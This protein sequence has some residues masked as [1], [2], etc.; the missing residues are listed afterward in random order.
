VQ[1]V[2]P[3]SGRTYYWNEQTHASQW[4][5]PAAYGGGG[6]AAAVTAASAVASPAAAPTDAEQDAGTETISGDVFHNYKPTTLAFG[7]EH[8]GM[9]VEA[10]SLASIDLPPAT[11]P[12]QESLPPELIATG[13]LSSLQLEGVLYA[14]QRHQ[15]ILHTGERAGFFLGAGVLCCVPIASAFTLSRM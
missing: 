2:E 14:C 9:I 12:L 1:V 7:C 10:S 11:F 6:A 13:Q 3:K 15:K 5:P 8:P 4:D